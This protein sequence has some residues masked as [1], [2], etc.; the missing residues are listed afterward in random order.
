MAFRKSNTNSIFF[1]LESNSSCAIVCSTF[2]AVSEYHCLQ[3]YCERSFQGLCGSPHNLI[4]NLSNLN[5]SVILKYHLLLR[6]HLPL[7]HFY[8]IKHHLGCPNSKRTP[9]VRPAH[10]TSIR[11]AIAVSPPV[12]YS[13]LVLSTLARRG[14]VM[15]HNDECDKFL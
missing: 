5:F 3:Q 6:F 14:S 15:D 4:S 9:Q 13:A 12:F 10:H 2:S 7:N 8:P 1:S 11:G